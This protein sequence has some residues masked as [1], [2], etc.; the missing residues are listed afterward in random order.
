MINLL[1]GHHIHIL[2]CKGRSRLTWC[3]IA[4]HHNV[5]R[6]D[7]AMI[8]T[9]SCRPSCP[10]EQ[11][12]YEPDTEWVNYWVFTQTCKHSGCAY[13]ACQQSVCLCM[14]LVKVL[15]VES[16]SHTLLFG[17][18][19]LQIR[20]TLIE[21]CLLYGMVWYGMVWDNVPGIVTS[22]GIQS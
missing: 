8:W 3:F 18:A 11:L 21:D 1:Y 22:H 17:H 2:S 5:P 4:I 13:R 15:P 9:L 20:Y 7:S 14:T 6:V 10:L 19:R 12:P 16:I